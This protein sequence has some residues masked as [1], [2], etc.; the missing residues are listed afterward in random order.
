MLT[1]KGGWWDVWCG[2]NNSLATD[3]IKPRQA[4]SAASSLLA[5]VTAFP[6]SP[7]MSV[8]V[9]LFLLFFLPIVA[10][11]G[12]APTATFTFLHQ[13]FCEVEIW[14][15][16]SCFAVVVY[17]A[18]SSCLGDGIRAMRRDPGQRRPDFGREYLRGIETGGWENIEM[19]SMARSE[20]VE[21]REFDSD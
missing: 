15:D 3:D 17:L 14:T 18:L 21:L 12:N 7:I 4:C 9:T 2:V 1:G 6:F 13:V 11:I 8:L 19:E 5:S 20:G 16:K 10:F